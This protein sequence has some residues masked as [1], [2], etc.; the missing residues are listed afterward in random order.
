MKISG[1]SVMSAVTKPTG[2]VFDLLDLSVDRFS[3]YV[4]DPMLGV[5]HNVVDTDFEHLR[6]FLDRLQPRMGG[7][8]VPALEVVAY[9]R[10]G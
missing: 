2:H 10:S 5:S 3:Q 6:R 4:G 8:E 7:P 1:G 9:M